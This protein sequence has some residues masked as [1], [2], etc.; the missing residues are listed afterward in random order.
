MQ[1]LRYA[2]PQLRAISLAHWLDLQLHTQSPHLPSD[3]R[4]I[5]VYGAFQMKSLA[6]FSTQTHLRWRFSA[7]Q[8]Q[9]LWPT[10]RAWLLLSIMLLTE[11]TQSFRCFHSLYLSPSA[12]YNLSLSMPLTRWLLLRQICHLLSRILRCLWIISLISPLLFQ[13]SYLPT[14]SR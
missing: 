10:T 13:T 2:V 14:S 8:R 12:Q 7:I 9:T 5:S 1:L 11:R 4:L 3:Q 6:L